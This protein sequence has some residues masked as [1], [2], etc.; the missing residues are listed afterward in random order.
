VYSF[1]NNGFG[2]LGIGS[3]KDENSP[4]KINFENNE[5]IFNIFSNCWSSGA[6]FYS[7]LNY[8]FLFF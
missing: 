1:G 2:D 3:L 7:S 4:K 8:F 5:Q 6:F